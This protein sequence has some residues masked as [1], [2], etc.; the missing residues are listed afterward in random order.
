MSV[1]GSILGKKVLYEN[2]Y[3]PQLLFPIARLNNRIELGLHE[4][5]IPFYGFDIWN[6]YEVSWLDLLGKPVVAIGELWFNADSTNIIE[7]KSM[8]LYLNSFNNTNYR[9]IEDVEKIICM[10]LSKATQSK[11]AVKL[12]Y[13]Q[14]L[15]TNIGTLAGVNIDALDVNCDA[16][17]APDKTLLKCSDSATSEEINSNLLK[18]NCLVTG[19]PDWASIYIRYVGKKLDHSSLI[20]YLVSFRNY[21]EFHEQCVER[22]FVDLLSVINPTFL[23]VYAK[24]TRR[25]GI[26][27][28][29]CRSTDSEI[30]NYINV[31]SIRLIRQ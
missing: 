9:S 16:Y 30:S 18:S 22:I 20:K 12:C 28:S 3:N 7:S 13:I 15:K 5:R 31:N 23:T 17:N 4:D 24:Y 14:D 29:P 2:Q 6:A 10:D 1:S 26:D 19:Q 21:N 27:I 8:K 25:G 11:V